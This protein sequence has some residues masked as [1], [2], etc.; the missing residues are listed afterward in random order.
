MTYSEIIKLLDAGYSRD[1]IM[2]MNDAQN[3]DAQNDDAQNDDAQNDAQND[4]VITGVMDE[5]KN[6]FAEMRKE[7]VA[8]NIMNSSI[9]PDSTQTSEDVIANIINPFNREEGDK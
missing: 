1:E 2:Q 7:L 8:M 6:M 4:D 9:G 5:V 3:D